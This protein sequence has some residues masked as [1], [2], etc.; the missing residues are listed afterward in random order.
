M[1]SQGL[2]EHVAEIQRFEELTVIFGS[3]LQ[4]LQTDESFSRVTEEGPV[5]NHKMKN[6]TDKDFTFLCVL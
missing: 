2:Y 4:D 5:T 1:K 6:C 3:Y